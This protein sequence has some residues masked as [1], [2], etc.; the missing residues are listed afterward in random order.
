MNIE[1]NDSRG[2]WIIIGGTIGATV[3]ASGRHLPVALAL[4]IGAGMAIGALLNRIKQSQ[5]Q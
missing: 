5:R 2:R 4:G 1:S 3:G